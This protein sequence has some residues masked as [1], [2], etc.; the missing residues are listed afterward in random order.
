MYL[1]LLVFHRKN[2]GSTGSEISVQNLSVC[3]D[4]CSDE[5]ID[6][7]PYSSKEREILIALVLRSPRLTVERERKEGTK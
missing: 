4:W 2:D 5:T 3:R 1:Q 7:A 6:D